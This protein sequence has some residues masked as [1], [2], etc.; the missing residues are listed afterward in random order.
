MKKILIIFLTFLICHSPS[1]AS[2]CTSEDIETAEFWNNYYEPQ[3]AYDFGIKIQ[4]I[5]QE[6]DLKSLFEFVKSIVKMLLLILIMVVMLKSELREVFLLPYCGLHCLLPF[7]GKLLIF[8]ISVAAIGMLIIAILDYGFE[9]FQHRTQWHRM[10]HPLH[11]QKPP[12]CF[13]RASWSDHH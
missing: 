6:K 9:H 10:A 2:N 7:T 4:N 12:K 5:V 1:M 8:M 11:Q 13:Q 3:E